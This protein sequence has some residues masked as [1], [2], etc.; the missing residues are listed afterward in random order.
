MK[1]IKAI[2]LT[3]ILPFCLVVLRARAQ[4]L[5][6]VRFENNLTWA[7]VKAKAKAENK[8]IFVDCYTTWCGPCKQMREEVFQRP[9]VG[10]YFNAHFICVSLQMD[11]TNN[12]APGVRAWYE[13]AAAIAKEYDVR[14]YP[15]YLFFAPD[16]HAVHR[17]SGAVEPKQFIQFGADAQD[18]S[19]QYYALVAGA[20]GHSADRAYLLNVLRQTVGMSDF[21]SARAVGALFVACVKDSPTEQ[22]RKIMND[23]SQFP[24]SP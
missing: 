22:D 23:I 10:T 1:T 12:D 15:T 3:L 2:T 16:G 8:G 17:A 19:R 13:D 11:R 5:E 6:G 14:Q 24:T 9:S 18:P 20:A 4:V 7:E 21:V